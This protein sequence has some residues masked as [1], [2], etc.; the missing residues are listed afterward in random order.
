M[1]KRFLR[2]G[3]YLLIFAFCISSCA[4]TGCIESS[5][6]LASEAKLPRW[7]ELPP[8][9]TRA[10]VS[11]TVDYHT[12]GPAKFILRD[13]KG[14]KLAEIKGKVIN[15]SPLY[16]KSCTQRSYLVCPGYEVVEV[17]G[18]TEIIKNVPYIEHANMEQNGRVVALFYVI[19]DPA[20]RKEILENDTHAKK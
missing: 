9:L 10:D 13:K 20:V 3:K 18:I 1:S 4:I 16:L 8:G 11:V 6:N 15:Q 19:D 17:N 5:F 12:L 2:T 14:K 7:M